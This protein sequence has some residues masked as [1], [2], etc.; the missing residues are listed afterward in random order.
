MPNFLIY[1]YLAQCV[2]YVFVLEERNLM[3]RDVGFFYVLNSNG[4]ED[5]EDAIVS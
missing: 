3:S 4:R 1:H 2:F 5:S